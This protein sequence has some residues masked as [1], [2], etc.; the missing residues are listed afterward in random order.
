[1]R[2]QGTVLLAGRAGPFIYGD[3]R[4]FDRIGQG[5]LKGQFR[6]THSRTG[7]VVGLYFLSGATA[8]DPK[9]WAAAVAQLTAARALVHPHL[10][11]VFEP[12]QSG[13]YRFVGIEDLTGQSLTDRLAA[14]GRLEANV[15]CRWA[16]QPAQ[17]F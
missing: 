13:N 5:R 15:A 11:R 10:S 9:A 17:A 16:R 12:V 8:R 3:Y 4:V 7:A 14:R 6:A 1:S 2:Y